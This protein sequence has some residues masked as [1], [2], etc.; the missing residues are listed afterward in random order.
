MESV[1]LATVIASNATAICPPGEFTL[2]GTTCW[3]CP[4]GSFCSGNNAT[5]PCADGLTWSGAAGASACAPCSECEW[6]LAARCSPTLDAVCVGCPPGHECADGVATA[7]A[8]GWFSVDGAGAC[9]PCGANHTTAAEGSTSAADCVC[10]NPQQDQCL[11]CEPGSSW[12]AM[13]GCR[14][15][16][17]G[18][19][20]FFFLFFFKTLDL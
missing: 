13:G 3:P 9:E 16:P 6:L 12:S 14:R 19:F 8:R 15:C 7:C 2:A 18:F 10:E 11:A 5:Q 1:F 17:A 4:P 20:C